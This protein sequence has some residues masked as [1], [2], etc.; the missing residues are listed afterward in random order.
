LFSYGQVGDGTT[1]TR[2]FPTIVNSSSTFMVLSGKSI[3]QITA[4]SSHTCVIANDSNSYC[5]GRNE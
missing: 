4:G 1:K 3:L 2:L 5:W